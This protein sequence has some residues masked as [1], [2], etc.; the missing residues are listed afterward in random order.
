MWQFLENFKIGA[1][2]FDCS[3]HWLPNESNLK[4]TLDVRQTN[5]MKQRNRIFEIQKWKSRNPGGWN[6][7][8][9]PWSSLRHIFPPLIVPHCHRG[10]SVQKAQRK[11]IIKRQA[12]KKRSSEKSPPSLTL[13]PLLPYFTPTLGF[14]RSHNESNLPSKWSLFD[15]RW[16]DFL[17]TEVLHCCLVFW[18]FLFSSSS[19]VLLFQRF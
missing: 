4:H 2:G 10:R 1:L 9:H 6:N 11:Y 14:G 15:R 12:R 8:K 3:I 13:A 19:I 17:N 7:W 16:D 18:H 5:N